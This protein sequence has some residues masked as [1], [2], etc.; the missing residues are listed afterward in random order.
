[1]YLNEQN[2]THLLKKKHKNPHKLSITP[3]YINTY[4]KLIKR[5]L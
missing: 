5:K 3:K 4:L 1:M 2:I